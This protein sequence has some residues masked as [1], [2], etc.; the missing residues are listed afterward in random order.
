MYSN[1]L[2]HSWMLSTTESRFHWYC[3]I[4]NPASV[5]TPNYMYILSNGCSTSL[6]CCDEYPVAPS[7]N[8]WPILLVTCNVLVMGMGVLFSFLIY[9]WCIDMLISLAGDSDWRTWLFF[10]FYWHISNY[11]YWNNVIDHLLT[12]CDEILVWRAKIVAWYLWEMIHQHKIHQWVLSHH[13]NNWVIITTI[14][15]K[16]KS[17]IGCSIC[18]IDLGD[19]WL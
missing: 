4:A 1:W 10:H 6:R 3:D 12:H 18:S 13:R 2:W 16:L 9:N 7:T 8:A 5:N 17:E 11:G 19:G 14:D 15:T